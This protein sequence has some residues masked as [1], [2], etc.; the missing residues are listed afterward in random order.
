MYTCILFSEMISVTH[1]KQENLDVSYRILFDQCEAD[2]L[3]QQLEN[4]VTY[5]SGNLAQLKVVE[6]KLPCS[7]QAN[8]TNP[9]FPDI[10]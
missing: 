7:L 10:W 5:Y 6:H 4:E 1:Y 9:I 3:F 2:E 8:I